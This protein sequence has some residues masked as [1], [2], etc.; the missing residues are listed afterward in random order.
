MGRW[1]AGRGQAGLL[2]QGG[3]ISHLEDKGGAEV[4]V[5]VAMV[6]AGHP[7][8]AGVPG[9]EGRDLLQGRE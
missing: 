3:Q 1:G 5:T 4:A 8:A 6:V 7:G 9:L 2:D